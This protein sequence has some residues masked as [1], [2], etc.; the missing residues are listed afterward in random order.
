MTTGIAHL[1]IIPL[2]STPSEKSEMVSQLLFGEQY[3]VI[4]H[5]GTWLKIENNWDLYQG[6]IDEKMF[7]PTSEDFNDFAN[8][9]PVYTT[10]GIHIINHVFEKI[11]MFILHGSILPGY[12]AVT[13]TF[14][15]AD[16]T[17]EFH[18]QP[19]QLATEISRDKIV[20]LAL[21]FLNAPYLWGGR[22]IFGIDCSGFV[23]LVYKILGIKL[24]RDAYQQYAQAVEIEM[25]DALPG[26]LAFFGKDSDHI[27]HVGIML[28]NRQIIHAAGKVR[29]DSLNSQGIYN[30]E[31]GKYTHKLVCC[32][33][34]LTENTF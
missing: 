11:P 3:K 33:S 7:L 10:R 34:V 9:E 26:D 27:T 32:K 18:G 20:K 16:G 13:N 28:D 14:K 5:E 31:E 12:N 15:L 8:S 23:Q 4:G 21:G 30:K 17:F 24:L 25:D 29:I 6:W 2:R 19:L 22:S 1:S